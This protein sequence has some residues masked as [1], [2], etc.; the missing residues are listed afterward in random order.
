MTLILIMAFSYVDCSECPKMYF[1]N[2]DRIPMY[3][4]ISLLVLMS[5]LNFLFEIT[6]H[7]N[8]ETT[9]CI[10]FLDFFIFIIFY[11][12][13]EILNWKFKR[14]IML[15]MYA[16]IDVFWIACFIIWILLKSVFNFLHE[17]NKANRK[18]TFRN[19]LITSLV[20]I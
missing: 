11:L 17:L 14:C 19:F 16:I 8:N 10:F 5:F 1:F 4:V 13:F 20:S 15:F 12:K 6:I 18:S 3:I 2:F 9:V 7:S